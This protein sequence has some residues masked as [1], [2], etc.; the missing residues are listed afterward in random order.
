[1]PSGRTRLEQMKREMEMVRIVGGTRIA[2]PPAGATD[3]T[4][5]NLL[6]AA[7]RYGVLLELGD[8]MGVVPQLEV[9]G[10][11]KSLSKLGETVYVAMES[12][13]ASA[14]VLPDIYHLYKGGSSISGL[15][16]L[17][18]EAIHCIHVNDYPADPP[19][20]TITDAQ[21]VYPGDGVAQLDE[22]FRT[23]RDI[24]F[25][26]ALSLELFNRDYWKQDVSLVLKTGLE[27]TKAAVAKALA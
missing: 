5:L 4:N 14:C 2:A 25:H 22:I 10:F 1:M 21:R 27:K 20:E 24:G 19:R 18:A 9:W 23:L 3:Q 17:S 8:E 7:E 13:H 15:N 6:A 11:S 16:M 26:G 12:G